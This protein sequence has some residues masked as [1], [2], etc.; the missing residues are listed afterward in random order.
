MQEQPYFQLLMQEQ[1]YFHLGVVVDQALL[2]LVDSCWVL[3][4]CVAATHQF[5]ERGH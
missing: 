1:P 5:V 2:E 3:P 4:K